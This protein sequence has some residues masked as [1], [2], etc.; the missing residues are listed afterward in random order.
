MK[1]I[2]ML[3]RKQKNEE[4]FKRRVAERKKRRMRDDREKKLLE[5]EAAYK[6]A[7]R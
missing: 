2:S 3:A 5:H 7:E 4:R 1:Y 6:C